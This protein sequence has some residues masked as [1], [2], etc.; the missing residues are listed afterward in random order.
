[1]EENAENCSL[2]FFFLTF[3]SIIFSLSL[4]PYPRRFVRGD[5]IEGWLSLENTPIPFRPLRG[6]S[7]WTRKLEVGD[8]FIGREDGK[9][10]DG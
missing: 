7:D 8:E 10:G 3:S 2:L 6:M 5:I 1:M 9:T 4:F